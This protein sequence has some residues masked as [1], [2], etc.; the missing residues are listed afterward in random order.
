MGRNEGEQFYEQ[1]VLLFIGNLR[2][3]V[4][5]HLGDEVGCWRLGFRHTARL[6]VKLSFCKRTPWTLGA[7]G[8]AQGCVAETDIN[9]EILSISFVE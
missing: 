8:A 3:D 1:V 9:Y 2:E 6:W 5:G 7:K 4:V